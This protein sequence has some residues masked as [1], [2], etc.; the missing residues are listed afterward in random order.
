MSNQSIVL[1]SA[2]FED[3]STRL[4]ELPDR[5]V[6]TGFMNLDWMSGIVAASGYRVVSAR[7]VS[8]AN[9]LDLR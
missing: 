9:V 8:S 4:R 1:A 5:R 3:V 2:A 6:D 7:Q